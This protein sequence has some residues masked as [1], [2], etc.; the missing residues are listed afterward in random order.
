MGFV[1]NVNTLAQGMTPTAIANT[2]LIVDTVVPHMTEILL[3]DD[4]AVIATAKAAEATADVILTHADVVLTHADVVLTH[5]DVITTNADAVVCTTQANA[6]ILASNEA[7]VASLITSAYGNVDWAG[8][9][10]NDGELLV[11]YF[12]SSASVPSLVDGEFILTY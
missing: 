10:H 6:A 12:S 7:Q 2:Q 11:N 3:A 9:V 5:A 8:F 4:N 1:E